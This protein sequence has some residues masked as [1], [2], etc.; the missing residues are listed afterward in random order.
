[1]DA[2]RSLCDRC[3]V[4]NAAA[5][6]P[7][8]R[9]RRC[10]PSRRSCGPI[11]ETPMLEVRGLTVALRQASGAGRRRPRRRSAGEIV[12]IL[13]ANGAGKIDAAQGHRRPGRRAERRAR[14]RFNGQD[15]LAL[16]AAR[17]RRGRHR[18][19]AGRPRHFRRTDGAREL[20]LGA[21]ARRARAGRERQPRPR[22]D[23][24][25]APRR[26]AAPDRPH[27]ERRRA[28]DGGDRPRADVRAGAAAAR[29]AVARPVAAAVRGT[30]PGAGALRE[31]GVGILLVEQN[32]RRAWRSPTA[33]I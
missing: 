25:P 5:R 18:A 19:G 16:A 17:D 33:A 20:E 24:V 12:V 26:A 13:G 21:Y 11:S 14:S 28:A 10:S 1:M 27:D 23:A 6:S 29:R 22:A 2:I 15:L 31:T 8:A 4:M 9:P 32:A 30:V 7:K 3:I